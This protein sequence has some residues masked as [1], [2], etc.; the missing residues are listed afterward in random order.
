[1]HALGDLEKFIH[2][3][4]NIPVLVR[5]AL[6]HA[7][8]ETIHPFLDGNG[9]IGRLLITFILVHDNILQRP[10]LYLSYY[11][12]QNRQEYYD[13]L[14]HVRHK[15]NWEG[16][17]KFFLK[18]VCE[19]SSQATE[20]AKRIIDL[21]E[22]DKSRVG[23]NPNAMKLLE[24]LFMNPLVTI[25][26]IRRL[27]GVSGATAGRLVNYMIEASI[28]TEITGYARNRKF[29]YKNYFNILKEGIDEN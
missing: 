29:L 27:T 1:L 5:S 21:Q 8:F 3:E 14:N 24:H 12:K 17:L 23:N 9:R 13:R 16:W 25:R 22:R 10:L 15:G 18:G 11:F 19:V 4:D 7:Q 20:T 2:R 26:E 6:I 28:L